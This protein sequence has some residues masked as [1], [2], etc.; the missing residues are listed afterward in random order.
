LPVAAVS[1]YLIAFSADRYVVESK[2]AIRTPGGSGPNDLLSMFSSVTAS[3]S[4]VSDSYMVVEFME[5][6]D[7]VDRL[8]QR[9]DLRAVYDHPLADPLMRLD[10][11][12]SKEAVASYMRR[13][14]S[15]YF[16][17]SSQILTLE[18]QAFTPGDAMRV[19]EAILEIIA[20]LVNEVSE[21]ARADTMRS[22][23]RE[24]ARIESQLADHRRALNSFRQ[25]E[26]DIDPA[27]SAVTQIQLLG[28]LEARLAEKRAQLES[29]LSFLDPDAPSIRILRGQ[30]GALETQVE[31]QR[32]RLGEGLPQH[33][34]G[35]RSTGE[36]PDTVMPTMAARVGIYEDLAVDL[37]FLQQAYFAALAA[38]EAARLEADRAQRYLAVF[39]RPSLP[40]EAL[41]PHRLQSILFFAG[42]AV[43]LWAIAVMVVYIVREHST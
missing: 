25:T 16:D 4:T 42:F 32:A 18:V 40:E 3:T 9:I 19:S 29:M 14:I 15:I 11:D 17:S 26:Q 23:G 12:S 27:A 2:F 43:M 6:R 24:V 8:D 10:S 1:T 37:E 30:I 28:D 41:Y 38:R 33:D 5:S 7:L 20:D 39:V 35:A 31:T 34:E 36:Q 22:A 13:V 21:R